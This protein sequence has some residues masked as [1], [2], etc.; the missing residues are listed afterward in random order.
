MQNG[1]IGTFD[2]FSYDPDVIQQH[3]Q[4]GKAL[5]LVLHKEMPG[6]LIVRGIDYGYVL[7]NPYAGEERL[8]VAHGC[9][10]QPVKRFDLPDPEV[11][12]KC[13][14]TEQLTEGIYPKQLFK[15][16]LEDPLSMVLSDTLAT[17]DIDIFKENYETLQ[18]EHEGK[19]HTAI[20]C[21]FYD[22]DYQTEGKIIAQ[23]YEHEPTA[24]AAQ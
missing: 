3:L 14:K 16:I 19:P 24:I 6:F 20:A 9:Y 15:A 22:P 17:A 1:T 18:V 4:T 23:W 8:V 21:V 7:T 10:K 2:F 5:C 12:R 13:K 11:I